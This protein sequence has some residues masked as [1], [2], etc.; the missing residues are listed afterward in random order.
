MMEEKKE[1]RKKGGHKSVFFIEKLTN[2]ILSI[3]VEHLILFY[4]LGG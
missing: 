2:H 3:S 4:N 1:E